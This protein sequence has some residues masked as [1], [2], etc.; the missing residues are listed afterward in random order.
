MKFG[1]KNVYL[2]EKENELFYSLIEKHNELINRFSELNNKISRVTVPKNIRR[3]DRNSYDFYA[4]KIAQLQTEMVK[5]ENDTLQFVCKPSLFFE[6]TGHYTENDMD[7]LRDQAIKVIEI[8]R[9]EVFN[10]RNIL[11]NN[12]ENLIQE[13]ETISNFKIA[14]RSYRI[15]IIGLVLSLIGLI[16]SIF[17]A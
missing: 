11:V 10:S 6:Y 1:F 16:I 13:A 12:Y 4:S 7:F 8:L 2:P 15:A 9:N 14:I 5:Y 17:S 3:R